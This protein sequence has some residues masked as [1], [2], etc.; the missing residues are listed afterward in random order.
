MILKALIV[1]QLEE[2]GILRSLKMQLGNRGELVVAFPDEYNELRSGPFHFHD[3][4]NERLFEEGFAQCTARRLAGRAFTKN[5]ETFH[6]ETSWYGIPTERNCISYYALSLPRFAVPRNVSIIDPHKRSKEYRRRVSRDDARE[7]FVIY[8]E[9]S[10]SYGRFDFE[11]SLDYVIDPDGFC[12]STY[13]D[14]MTTES[15]R[16]GDEWRHCV[17]ESQIAKVEQFF[18]HVGDRYNTGQ[19][20]AVGRNAS[21]VNNIFR[22]FWRAKP[23]PQR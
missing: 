18:V 21:I 20:A 9:C 3:P 16:V 19:A 22:Q 23:R 7:R 5:Q 15:G 12:V 10:S 11:L 2:T 8:L 1:E 13:R 14:S 17:D 4:E 6:T